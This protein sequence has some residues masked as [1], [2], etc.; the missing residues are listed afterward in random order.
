MGY[1]IRWRIERIPARMVRHK[2]VLEKVAFPDHGHLRGGTAPVVTAPSP[3]NYAL[4]GALCG[5]QL[6]VEVASDKYCDH[7][8]AYRQSE[9]FTR[10][11]I[12]LSRSTLVDWLMAFAILLGPIVKWL[13]DQVRGGGWLRADATGLPVLDPPRV[14]GKAHHGHLWAW[15]N[16]DTVIFQ[17]TDKIGRAHV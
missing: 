12:D 6:L 15:G 14:K 13:G 10:E 5:N 8:P 17:Y 16:Y 2:I 3:V 9:R 7:L 1:D 11:G 4:P